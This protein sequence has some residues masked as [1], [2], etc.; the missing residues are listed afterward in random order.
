MASDRAAKHP[1]CNRQS[2]S[3]Q[4]NVD[5]VEIRMPWFR[6]A[7]I[8]VCDTLSMVNRRRRA[9]CLIASGAG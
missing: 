1:F 7:E 2:A 9:L 4:S 5:P 3:T 6:A 8:P